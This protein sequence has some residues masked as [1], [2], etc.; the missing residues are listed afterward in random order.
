MNSD[1]ESW[2]QSLKPGDE[3]AYCGGTP[4]IWHVTTVTAVSSDLIKTPHWQFYLSTGKCSDCCR[5]G[6]PRILV[7]PDDDIRMKFHRQKILT[8]V[9]RF[10][11]TKLNDT[12]LEQV[13]AIISSNWAQS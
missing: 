1:Y 4:D 7:K 3:V 8:A 2:L 13:Y 9:N 5:P 12:A 11:W 10:R 6:R